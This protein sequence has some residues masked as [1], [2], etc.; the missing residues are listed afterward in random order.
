[1][2]K[3]NSDEKFYLS[4][5]FKRIPLIYWLTLVWYKCSEENDFTIEMHYKQTKDFDNQE[6]R[7]FQWSRIN[8]GITDKIK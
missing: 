2:E 7:D 8:T 4:F 3:K 5:F 6:E 1:M